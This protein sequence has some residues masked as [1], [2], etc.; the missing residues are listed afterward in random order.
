MLKDWLEIR[1]QGNFDEFVYNNRD[2]LADNS[3]I[4]NYNFLS[5]GLWYMSDIYVKDKRLT[6]N[7]WLKR[8]LSNCNADFIK[9]FQLIACLQKKSVNCYE[10]H[11]EIS[12]DL[13]GKTYNV[14]NFVLKVIFK[15]FLSVKAG[16]VHQVQHQ[17]IGKELNLS[18]V[19]W[20]L[21][22]TVLIS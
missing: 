2:F 7:V 12:F 19:E 8:G 10:K 14:S 4:F 15:K 22:I 3:M 11:S 5:C 17:S 18:V 13:L 21:I 6:Y 9:W 1:Q 20:A 16:N